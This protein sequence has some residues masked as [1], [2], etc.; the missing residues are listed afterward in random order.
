MPGKLILETG[1]LRLH[2]FVPDDADAFF[3]LNSDLEVMRYTGAACFTSIEQARVSLCKRPIADYRKHGFG[4][5]AVVL[6]SHSKLIGFAGLKHLDDL[7]EVDLGYRLM[8][9]YWGQGLASEA[10]RA[11]VT[12]GFQGVSA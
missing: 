5:W 6:K 3:A 1:R 2:E 4:R 12:H 7:N 10:S 11:C 8:V 9:A